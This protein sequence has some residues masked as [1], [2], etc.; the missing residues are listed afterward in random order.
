M[1][2][3]VAQ[4][5]LYN[6]QN[7]FGATIGIATGQ[8][9]IVVESTGTYSTESRAARAGYNLVNGRLPNEDLVFYEPENQLPS[10]IS[11]SVE[12]FTDWSGADFSSVVSHFA[13][14]RSGDWSPPF[15][16]NY[17]KPPKPPYKVYTDGSYTPP[18]HQDP[19]RYCS[20]VGYVIVG[21]NDSMYAAGLPTPVID[22]SLDAEYYAILRAITELDVLENTTI[23]TDH[24]NVPDVQKGKAP[25]RSSYITDQ[26]EQILDD[27]PSMDIECAHRSKTRLSDALATCAT[28]RGTTSLGSLSK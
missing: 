18:S 25:S 3:T 9:S 2:K 28:R 27:N 7:S 6:Q 11:E 16:L 13:S 22:D 23:Y 5:S 10:D 1:Q 8:R 26:L 4:I 14:Y 20:G 15:S 17:H 24:R 19:D 21:S 12:H